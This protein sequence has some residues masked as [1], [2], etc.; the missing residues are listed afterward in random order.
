VESHIIT[1]NNKRLF[2][3]KNRTEKYKNKEHEEVNNK[4]DSYQFID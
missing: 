3:M 4:D 1:G 2:N